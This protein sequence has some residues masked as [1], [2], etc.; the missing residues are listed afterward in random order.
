[1]EFINGLLEHLHELERIL[2]IKLWL[3]YESFI[4]FATVLMNKLARITQLLIGEITFHHISSFS[5][6]KKYFLRTSQYSL[7]SKGRL[8]QAC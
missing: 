2:I 7:Q 1:M 6:H 3:D 8:C 4:M 5:N